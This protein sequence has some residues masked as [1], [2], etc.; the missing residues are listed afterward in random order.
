MTQQV[1]NGLVAVIAIGVIAAPVV[2]SWLKGRWWIGL[3]GAVLF[4][5]AFALLLGVVGGEPDAE[6]QQTT[7]F[8]VV[9]AAIN[10]ALYG[11]GSLLLFG[12]LFRPRP[13]SWSDRNRSA[14]PAMS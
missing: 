11:G 13:G 6:F 1:V 5:T 7:T 9:E 8:K 2:V 14:K 10:I 3:T 12:A 4:V